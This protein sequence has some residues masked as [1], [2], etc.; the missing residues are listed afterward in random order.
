MWAYTSSDKIKNDDIRNK[1]YKNELSDRQ[2]EE[3]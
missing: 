1:V 2:D 3:C